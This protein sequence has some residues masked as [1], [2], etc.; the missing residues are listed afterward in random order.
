VLAVFVGGVIVGGHAQATGLTQ[1]SDPLRGLLLG[2]SGQELSR[3]VLDVLE[4]D[5]Y[6]PVDPTELERASVQAIV[7]S[8]AD[9]YT[10]YLDPDELEALRD[11]NDGAY[12][13]VGLQV[14]ERDASIVVTHVFP[15]SPAA[16]AKILTGDRLVAVDGTATAGRGL[17]AV[18]GDI[19]GPEGSRV[20]LDVATGAGPTRTVE[21]KRARIRVP[22][23][24][25][26]LESVGGA[27]VGYVRLAQ[28]TRG[29][30]KALRDAVEALRAKGATG[31][32]LDLRGDPG[33][34][35][36]EAVGVTGAFLPKG[37]TVVVTE[38]LHSARH[39]FRTDS[40][41]VVGDLTVAVLVDRNSAS[42]SEIVS[43]A[44]RDAS[45]GR[46]VGERTFGKALVQSTVLLRDGG[47]LK[48]TTARYLTPSGFDLATRGLPPDVKVADDPATPVDEVLGRGLAIA[49]AG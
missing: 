12:F 35:V 22:S 36:T 34:L 13:G 8:L 21:L 30:A 38:G 29:S 6:V 17:E 28:F 7:D 45:R 49:A 14:A 43:G 2:D 25:S 11:R 3:Q 40:K 15:D 41:P 44:L 31:L 10:D 27:K 33:G 32:V 42:A 20:S 24:T 18:V 4:S 47:A 39:V 1:L 37:S 5:Y 16:R 9:P 23:V 19:R 46:L 26:R 48:L